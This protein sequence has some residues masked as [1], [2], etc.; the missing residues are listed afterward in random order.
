M[1]KSQVYHLLQTVA[2]QLRKQADEAGMAAAGVSAA[3]GAALFAIERSP[4]LSQREMAKALK[5]QESAVTTM[6]SR[7]MAAELITRAPRKEDPRILSLDLTDK[8]RA[9]LDRLRA[10]LDAINRA[11]EETLAP[12]ELEMLGP[13]L[14][15]LAANS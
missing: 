11:I 15:R 14:E 13:A 1:E 10:E 9:A 2:Q 5:Q 4:G 3:Q 8:G 6:V 12:D 7:L